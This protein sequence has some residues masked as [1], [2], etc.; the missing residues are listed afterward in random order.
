MW[1]LVSH[2][3]WT[4][5]E[6]VRRDAAN[7]IQE[8]LENV[9]PKYFREKPEIQSDVNRKAVGDVVGLMEGLRGGNSATT[10]HKDMLD[11]DIVRSAINE[12]LGDPRLLPNE[13][14]ILGG[15][16]QGLRDV[17]EK[18]IEDADVPGYGTDLVQQWRSNTDMWARAMELGEYAEKSVGGSKQYESLAGTL[19]RSSKAFEQFS[20]FATVG[21]MQMF[22]QS[23]AQELVQSKT[24]HKQIQAAWQKINPAARAVIEKSTVNGMGLGDSLIAIG[25]LRD[26]AE[27]EARSAASATKNNFRWSSLKDWGTYLFASVVAEPMYEAAKAIYPKVLI[28]KG[29]SAEARNATL[30]FLNGVLLSGGAAAAETGSGALAREAVHATPFPLNQY[31]P[32]DSAREPQPFSR[33]NTF[34]VAP[35]QPTKPKTLQEVITP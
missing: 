18:I 31:F 22:A 35:P 29:L 8:V 12:K 23:V 30:K 9:D 20:Q 2:P 14:R 26:I 33:A 15:L 27:Y 28:E 21:D 6:L 16:Q 7:G 1:D 11:I 13:K 17:Q 32:E 25:T 4:G 19:M 34:K 24:T 5:S 3:Q 10:T